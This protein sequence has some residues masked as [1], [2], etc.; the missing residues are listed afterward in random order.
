MDS[1]LRRYG[2]TMGWNNPVNHYLDFISL[3]PD[4][5]PTIP[6]SLHSIPAFHTTSVSVTYNCACG[7]W[8]FLPLLRD[9]RPWALSADLHIRLAFSASTMFHLLTPVTSK[10][11]PQFTVHCHNILQPPN[12]YLLVSIRSER[13]RGARRAW[14]PHS[15]F[16][17][18]PTRTKW[19]AGR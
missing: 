1:S 12:L 18:H 17:Y 10:C 16:C 3:G 8:T 14:K 2:Q 4:S 9:G 11:I 7:V 15:L 19:R 13:W 6:F 5:F